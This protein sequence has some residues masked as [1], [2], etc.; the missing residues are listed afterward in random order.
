[1]YRFKKHN[2]AI[3]HH[4]KTLKKI[5]LQTH[6]LGFSIPKLSGN[7]LNYITYSKI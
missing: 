1:M 2:E 4:N 5:R 3:K 7:K 6:E